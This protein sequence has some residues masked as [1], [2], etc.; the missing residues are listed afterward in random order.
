[1]DSSQ[2]NEKDIKID[3]IEIDDDHEVE[4]KKVKSIEMKEINQNRKKDKI[5]YQ[6]NDHLK[7]QSSESNTSQGFQD[8]EKKVKNIQEDLNENYHNSNQI[9]KFKVP[10]SLKKTFI[11]SSILF[12]IGITLI[13]LGSIQ[14]IAEAD[15]GKGITF[16]V[17]GSIILIPG[18]YYTYQF[19]KARRAR[20]YDERQE[21]LD[22]IPEL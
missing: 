7:N 18:G 15:P 22:E 16:W 20:S 12:L 4:E 14:Q 6:R 10:P 13:I 3:D 11:C 1:M 17:L 2:E 5:N 8:E 19:Y 21:I 9:Q